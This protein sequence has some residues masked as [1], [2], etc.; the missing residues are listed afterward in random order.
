MI[1]TANSTHQSIHI[2]TWVILLIA[3]INGLVYLFLIPPWQHYDEPGHFE[4]VWLLAK[5]GRKPIVGE[6]DAAM[7]REMLSSMVEHKFF[8]NMGGIPNLIA[9]DEAPWIG[10]EQLD[11]PA[12]YYF[13]VSLPLRLFSGLDI[14]NQLYIARLAS[15][16]MFLFA[17]W[18]AS[19]ASRDLFGEKSLL[20]V[21]AP[22]FMAGLPGFVELMTAVN[23]DVGAI[24]IS[25]LFYWMALRI[26]LFGVNLKRFIVL[27]ISC[28]IGYYTKAT[29]YQMLFMAPLILLWGVPGRRN[30]HIVQWCMS[31]SYIVGI[32]L[33]MFNWQMY[34]PAYFYPERTAILYPLQNAPLGHQVL[35][36]TNGKLVRQSLPQKSIEEIQGKETTIGGWMWA[37]QTKSV[38]LP[39]LVIDGEKIRPVKDQIEIT[40]KPTYYSYTVLMPEKISRAWLQI[41][42]NNWSEP[43]QLY[44]DGLVVTPKMFSPE[45]S[46]NFTD[47][48]GNRGEW[49]GQSFQNSLRNA[50]F[51]VGLPLIKPWAVNLLG[52]GRI[53]PDYFW[54]FLDWKGSGNYFLKG[55]W[56]ILQT[57]WGYFGWAHVPLLGEDWIYFVFFVFT[58]LGLFGIVFQIFRDWQNISW[59]ITLIFSAAVIGQLWIVLM[60]STGTWF[61][62]VSYPVARYFF[63]VIIPSVMGL[64]GGWSYWGKIVKINNHIATLVLV[65]F[66]FMLVVLNCWAWWSI[67]FYYGGNYNG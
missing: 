22:L 30:W 55:F 14:T 53:N 51:E 44:V 56:R 32:I 67:A 27:I 61:E 29:T 33:G 2:P 64:I 37:D 66:L 15:W 65:G 4:Y 42:T 3:A 40:D 5:T 18:V 36:L 31:F 50:S 41:D 63:P 8:H 1:N 19:R 34:T 43:N 17:V 23:N 57:F 58:I 39:S 47:D 20:S 25:C 13:I 48:N 52:K 60:R 59:S 62:Q 49:G 21:A 54:S 26:L 6:Y 11:D 7:R 35:S 46:P 38:S 28:L 10:V 16:M 45:T 24:A 9:L 12:L